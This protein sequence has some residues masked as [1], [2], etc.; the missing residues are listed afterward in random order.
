LR[1]WPL[2]ANEFLKTLSSQQRNKIQFG[3]DA[4]E[5]YNWHYIPK[6]RVG[7][8]LKELSDPQ[9]KAAMALLHTALSDTGFKKNNIHHK[10]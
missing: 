3:F 8:P 2:A 7:L 6:S 4:D 9:K 1:E 5:R 10:T